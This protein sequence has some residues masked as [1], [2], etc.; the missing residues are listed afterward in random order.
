MES[1]WEEN[2]TFVLLIVMTKYLSLFCVAI[3]E[4]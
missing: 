3:K 4:Y 2:K 1:K